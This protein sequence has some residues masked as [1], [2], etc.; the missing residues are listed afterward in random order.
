[1]EPTQTSLS[2]R[3]WRM[4][5]RAIL[6]FQPIGYFQFQMTRRFQMQHRRPT[7]I[8]RRGEEGRRI[9]TRE[10]VQRDN[11]KEWLT[12]HS[13]STCERVNAPKHYEKFNKRITC[14]L[15]YIYSYVLW[16]YVNWDNDNLESLKQEKKPRCWENSR[17]D[18]VGWLN[19]EELRVHCDVLALIW[20]R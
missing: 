11:E 13:V 7:T 1:M 14:T 5:Y 16:R 6:K 8:D 15:H 10:I 12:R 19:C 4:D 18:R 9:E 2:F 20:K 17:A 3:K